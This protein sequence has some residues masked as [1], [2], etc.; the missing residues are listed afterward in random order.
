MP[1]S[2]HHLYRTLTQ[3]RKQE[4]YGRRFVFAWNQYAKLKIFVWM[5]DLGNVSGNNLT[6]DAPVRNMKNEAITVTR[7]LS[8]W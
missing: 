5:G 8:E 1:L 3:G 7:W 6:G 4:S 2:L